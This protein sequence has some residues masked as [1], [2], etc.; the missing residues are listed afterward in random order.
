MAAGPKVIDKVSGT[1]QTTDAATVTTVATYTMLAGTT[2]YAIFRL[3]GRDAAGNCAS[4]ERAAGTKDPAG[5]VTVSGT[6]TNLVTFAN[7]S[8]AALSTCVMTTD[9]TGNTL[10]L[11]VQGIAATTIDWFGTIEIMTS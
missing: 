10:R 6:A 3:V 11:R 9:G 8:D 2:G 1:V 7:G 5:T 4:A